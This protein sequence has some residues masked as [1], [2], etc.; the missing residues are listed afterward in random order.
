MPWKCKKCTTYLPMIITNCRT[1]PATLGEILARDRANNGSWLCAIKGCYSINGNH[2]EK[3]GRLDCVGR[4][5][6]ELLLAL[7]ELMERAGKMVVPDSDEEAAV[8]AL[9][10]EAKISKGKAI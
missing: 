3:C 10:E 7:K 2:E 6:T 5:S 9:Y 4:K 8:Q 1:C